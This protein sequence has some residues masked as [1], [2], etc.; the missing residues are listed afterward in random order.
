MGILV[1][2]ALF[3]IPATAASWRGLGWRSLICV[4]LLLAGFLAA[5]GGRLSL[6]VE[7]GDANIGV[8]IVLYYGLTTLVSGLVARALSLAA[9]GLGHAR[10]WSLWIEALFFFGFPYL[11]RSWLDA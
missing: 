4:A 9:R 6:Q 2:A 5:T 7:S 1:A 10:P 8:G 11:V 3:A